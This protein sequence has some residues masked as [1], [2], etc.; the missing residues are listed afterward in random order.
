MRS[1]GVVSVGRSDYGIYLP[2]LRRMQAE[3]DLRL[4][5]FVSGMHLSPDFG[6]TVRM[7]EADGFEIAERVE[8]LVS[9][10]TPEGIAKSIGLGVIGFSQALPRNRPDILVILGDRFDMY[11]A[12]VAA[13]PFK[14]PVAHIHGGEVTYGAIDDALR[15]SMTKLSHLHFVSTQAYKQ[16]VEQLG[17]EPWRIA[18]SGAPGLDHLRSLQFLTASELERRYQLVLDP[19]PLLVTFH[20]VTL[21]YEQV[22]WQVDELLSALNAADLPI[23]FTMPNADTGNSVIRNKIAEFSQSHARVW[24]LDNLGTQ[25]YFS[26]MKHAAAMVGNSSSGI[27]EAASLKLPVV[28]IGSRQSGRIRAANV[29]DVGY[30][31][32][33]IQNAIRKAVSLAFREALRDLQNPYGDGHAAERI[34]DCLKTVELDER[35]LAKH[36]FDTR[37]V[38]YPEGAK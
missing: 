27:I 7:I 32:G 30:G 12:A 13:L 3:P 1:I 10:D 14:I 36:F 19:P 33:E 21:E 5:L 23:I 15:H 22:E 24:C 18:V 2:I 17:E 8:M 37:P 6:L 38:T 35:L 25:A 9:S 26:M 20:P 28:N 16:R 4:S 31:R 29:I 11:A 34:V